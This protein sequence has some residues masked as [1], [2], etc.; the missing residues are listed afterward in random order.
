MPKYAV[1]V[2]RAQDARRRALA[3]HGAEVALGLV[4]LS[5]VAVLGAYLHRHPGLTHLDRVGYGHI[6]YRRKAQPWQTIV[7][8]GSWPVLIVGSGVLVAVG[9]RRDRLRALA[10]GLAPLAATV[11]A[12][13]VLKPL[14]GRYIAKDELTYPSG[15]VVIVAA[16]ATA[17]VLAAPRRRGLVAAIGALVTAVLSLSV[18]VLRW[19][20][21]T[22]VVGGLL[23][24]PGTALLLD[25][26]AA[27]WHDL[28]PPPTTPGPSAGA[29]SEDAARAG[30]A[31]SAPGT[32]PGW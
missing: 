30:E 2:A 19:H 16:L 3:L 28:R 6:P 24:G 11:C 21:P 1:A 22:D 27:G 20:Y 26:A 14:V 15:T 10:C 7:L 17:T 4:A 25:G 5:L 8:V 9:W 32:S 18:L 23:L 29:G 31:S 12:D 13:Y